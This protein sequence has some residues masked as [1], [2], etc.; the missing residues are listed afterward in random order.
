MQN[1][2]DT[3]YETMRARLMAV[4]ADRTVVVRGAT[5]P[6]LIVAEN[7]LAATNL[8]ADCF[9]MVWSKASVDAAGAMPLVTMECLVRYRTAGNAA[10]AG[11]DRGRALAAMDAE[12]A[13]MV[14]ATPQRAAKQDFSMA[15]AM[16]TSVWWSDVAL[17]TAKEVDG[18]LSR[19]ANFT[20][21]AYQEAGEL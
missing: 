7:E 16:G 18:V 14:N 5:R 1:A 20:V 6:G 3:V 21:M 17:G 15:K 10:N 19:E 13:A 8:P 2:K 12:L 11:M 9:V 4:N